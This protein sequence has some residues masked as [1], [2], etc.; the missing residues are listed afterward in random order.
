MKARAPG[1]GTPERRGND[2]AGETVHGGSLSIPPYPSVHALF[3]ER[4]R[5]LG[6]R[7]A[8]RSLPEGGSAR[9]ETLSWSRWARESRAVSAALVRQGLE[10]GDAVGVLAGN[11]V[12]WPVTDL[13][14]VGAGAVGVGLYPTSAP[15]QIQEVLSDCGARIAVVDTPERLERLLSVRNE[16]PR[17]ERIVVQ[18]GA[19]GSAGSSGD[20]VLSWDRW[21]ELGGDALDRPEVS[22]DVE[23]RGNAAGPDDAAAL[24]YTSGST[25]TSKGARLTHRYLLASAASIRETLGIDRHD[26]TL[27]FLPYCHAAERV[28]GLYTRI[29][30]GMEAGLVE[31][32]RRLWE[33]ARAYEPTLFGGLP[34]FFE[35]IHEGVRDGSRPVTDFLGPRLRLATSGGAAL[36]PRVAEGLRE[37]GLTVL[38]AY[39]LTEHLCVAFNRP[40]RHALDSSGPPM[41]GTELRIAEDGEIL[42]RRGPLTFAGY[43]GRPEE[44]RE[45]FTEDGRWLRTGDIGEVDREGFLRVTGRKKELMAL[46]TGKMVAPRPV[47]AR[48]ASDPWVEEAV[49]VGDGRKYVSALLVPRRT[50]GERPATG[51]AQVRARIQEAVDRVNRDLSRSERIRRFALLDRPLSME[52]GELTPTGKVRRFRVLENHRSLVEELYAADPPGARRSGGGPDE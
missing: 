39:G 14:A 21:L 15:A 11:R 28:F 10:T 51:D 30:C 32:H 7:P 52:A 48:L 35:K 37:A 27:S 20:G 47:E 18:D 25:G 12:L 44:S 50:D 31:D 23:R 43:L 33:A 40:D 41:P 24:I 45:A 26:R 9:P 13:G 42:V 8:L 22:R 19:A 34:R 1:H 36:K 17:L 38:G 4:V 6:D 49:L 3:R 16:L 2:P 46:S 29:L 5:E